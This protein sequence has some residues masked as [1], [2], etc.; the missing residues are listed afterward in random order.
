[1]T[2]SSFKAYVLFRMT[3]FFSWPEWG[4][5]GLKRIEC[6]AVRSHASPATGRSCFPDTDESSSAISWPS[7]GAT[8]THITQRERHFS[9]TKEPFSHVDWAAHFFP[10]ITWTFYLECSRLSLGS[11]HTQWWNPDSSSQRWRERKPP[12]EIHKCTSAA[13]ERTS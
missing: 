12:V 6:S 7:P 11:C 2:N 4:L 5:L 13:H 3:T 9:I 8:N 1:M 10:P